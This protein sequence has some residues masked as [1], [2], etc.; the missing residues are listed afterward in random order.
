MGVSNP[1]KTKLWAPVI[2]GAALRARACLLLAS[3]SLLVACEPHS[4][5]DDAG[6]TEPA[7]QALQFNWHYTR[8]VE[9]FL[10]AD[11]RV[12]DIGSEGSVST[13][14][15][16]AYGA[17]FAL[18]ADDQETFQQV[19]TWAD[20]NLADGEL[21]DR[22]PAWQWG[23]NS[24]GD[25]G[26][27]D[28][29]PAIDADIWLTYSLFMAAKQW[30]RPR[31]EALARRLSR[32][33][34]ESSTMTLG[35]QRF[36]LPAPEGFVHEDYVLLNPSYFSLTLFTGLATLTGDER[37]Q[38]VAR[39]S[40]QVLAQL[41]A[42]GHGVAPDWLAVSRAGEV[43]SVEQ[44]AP[45]HQSA[46]GVGSYDAI[47]T[48]LWLAWAARY[49]EVPEDEQLLQDFA[50]PWQA[51]HQ[52]GYPPTA[53]SRP[54]GAPEG[55]GPIGFSAVLLPYLAA[56]D[57]SE[58]TVPEQQERIV[59]RDPERYRDNYYDHMLLLFGLSDACVSFTPAGL[60]ELSHGG[61]NDCR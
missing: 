18:L 26:V 29:N 35:D 20:H 34:L 58:E 48:Y 5:A 50:G 61:L 30:Q 19:L 46:V 44:T 17:W 56:L 21:G 39:S 2:H 14:E 13:S 51:T 33:I 32:R 10:S 57:T 49:S 12:V 23:Q 60:L 25:W 38:D 1:V 11:G 9:H 59:A 8:F 24:A 52:Q 42:E 40:R 43:L 36:L 4:P 6:D 28:D 54:A 27:L 37:W 45:T 16:Q 47:R 55:H 31:Y 53:L 41:A 15:G 7:A 3:L 22:L